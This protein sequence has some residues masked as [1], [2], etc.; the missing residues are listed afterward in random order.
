L[1]VENK[2]KLKR[3]NSDGGA[4]IAYKSKRQRQ[5]RRR[6]SRNSEK[7]RSRKMIAAPKRLEAKPTPQAS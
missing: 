7:R 4:K 6:R 1:D 3:R 5:I 2:I